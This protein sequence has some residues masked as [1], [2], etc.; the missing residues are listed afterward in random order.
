MLRK[1]ILQMTVISTYLE[2]TLSQ[3]DQPIYMKIPQGCK[4]KQEAL[5]Y[6]ILKSLYS[7]K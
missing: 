6:K 7:L 5:V 4:V 2:I 1:I 3:N